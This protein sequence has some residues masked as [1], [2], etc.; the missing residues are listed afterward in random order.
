MATKKTIEALAD[1]YGIR[2]DFEFYTENGFP[3]G[4]TRL[5]LP[6][7]KLTSGDTTGYTIQADGS[8]GQHLTE[9]MRDLRDLIKELG[10]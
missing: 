3:I 7:G 10:A 1:T 8:Y 9:V 2:V 4:E 5:T 6:D